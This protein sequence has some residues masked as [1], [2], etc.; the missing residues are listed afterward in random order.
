MIS[1]N[2]LNSSTTINYFSSYYITKLTRVF[3]CTDLNVAFKIDLE[4][5]LHIINICK[6]YYSSFKIFL[7][8]TYQIKKIIQI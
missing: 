4:F 8:S 7:C 3:D 5:Q 2:L 1:D 6:D